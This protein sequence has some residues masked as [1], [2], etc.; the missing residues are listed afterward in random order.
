MQKKLNLRVG[1]IVSCKPHPTAGHLYVEEIDV[2]EGKPRQVVSGLAK[3]IPIDKMQNRLVVLVCNM[4]ADKFQGVQSE[5][6]LL[7][8]NNTEGTIVELVEPPPT[9]KIG[10]R[11]AI[12]GYNG[13]TDP[14]PPV[15]NPKKKEFQVIK[16]DLR[17]N[18]LCVACYK[19]I[20]LLTSV[21]HCAVATLA[22]APLG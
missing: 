2:G 5:A 4:K 10:E 11:I 15:L 14:V 17:T 19:G 16:P 13:H 7:A 1:K 3:F 12:E 22:S 8:A 9:A 21:G 18:D 20:P 6:M